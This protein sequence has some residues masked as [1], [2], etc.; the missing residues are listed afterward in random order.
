MI[1][2]KFNCRYISSVV[3][4]N[5]RC[6]C[7]S[8]K[9]NPFNKIPGPKGPFNF[10]TIFTEYRS[11]SGKYNWDRLDKTGLKKYQEYGPIV[12]E[13]MLP[14]VYVVWLFDPTDIAAVLN[15]SRTGDYPQ[16]RS[17]LALEH[18]RKSKPEIYRTGGLLP[19]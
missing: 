14:G 3:I 8:S 15:D 10:G 19:T 13:K 17:H 9:P 6:L 1:K 12:R 4:V 16:R 11:T 5:K 7:S 2:F 18:Y